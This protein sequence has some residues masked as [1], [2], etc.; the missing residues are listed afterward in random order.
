MKELSVI[1]V[2]YNGRK[3]LQECVQSVFLYCK[4]IDLEIIIVDNNSTDNSLDLVLL[5]DSRIKVIK[6]QEN[7]GFSRA[8]NIGIKESKKEYILLLN[9]DTIL[10][11]P[12][13]VL[14][15]YIEKQERVGVVSIQMVDKNKQYR[16]STGYFPNLLNIILFRFMYH[17]FTKNQLKSTN[18][19]K[20]QWVE[21]SFLF[22]K[23]E[24]LKQVNGL[25][26]EY[27]MYLEDVDLCKRISDNGYDICFCP[28]LR[29]IHFGGYTNHRF[30]MHLASM[31]KYVTIH[32][33]GIIRFLILLIL[34]FKRIK[35]WL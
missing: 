28:K 26:N 15:E 35:T 34:D 25:S 13:D 30:S 1:I 20:V 18:F 10:L 31:R 5:K 2:N 22:I 7:L 4:G 3:F 23:R 27:F 12:L 21:G 14:F 9:N 16:C 11:D 19:E 6:N 17:R 33:K 29:Y 8:N 24:M 32:N